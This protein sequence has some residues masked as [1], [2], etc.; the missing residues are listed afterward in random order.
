MG[1]ASKSRMGSDCFRLA[2]LI[3]IQL[4]RLPTWP[5]GGTFDDAYWILSLYL[6]IIS[7]PLAMTMHLV[8][9]QRVY[10]LK[11]NRNDC[12]AAAGMVGLGMLLVGTD[13]ACLL[14]NHP[15][16]ANRYV[17]SAPLPPISW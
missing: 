9:K 1:S 8:W 3:F 14:R 2:V 7:L 13:S 15:Q 4:S 6:S 12:S 10:P 16:S 17:P 11:N 5:V